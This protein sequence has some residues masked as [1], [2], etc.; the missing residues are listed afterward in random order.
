[1]TAVLDREWP[2]LPPLPLASAPPAPAPTPKS[3]DC[4]WCTLDGGETGR[5]W[6]GETGDLARWDEGGDFAAPVLRAKSKSLFPTAALV[7]CDDTAD[8]SANWR[9]RRRTCKRN[10]A[11]LATPFVLVTSGGDGLLE[12]SDDG[13]V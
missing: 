5:S 8:A 10:E 12:C 11:A 9:D 6:V 2:L 7:S 3:M 13:K 1:M 4:R